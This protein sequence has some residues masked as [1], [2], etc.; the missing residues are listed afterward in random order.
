MRTLSGM[1]LRS[2]EMA[3]LLQ[4]STAVAESPMPRAFLTE[5]EVARVG[6]MPSSCTKTGFSN[7]MPLSS[8]ED[9]LGAVSCSIITHCTSCA[10]IAM[11]SS[12]AAVTPLL[13][14]LELTVAPVMAS[15]PS[16]S[17]CP[18]YWPQ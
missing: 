9:S 14:A 16:N 5:D 18:I 13:T 15:T 12:E 11:A 10:K 2:A 17:D 3:R 8:T 1:S 4:M 6:H 7:T